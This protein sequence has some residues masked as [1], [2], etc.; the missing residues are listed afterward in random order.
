MIERQVVDYKYVVDSRL[1]S[2]ITATLNFKVEEDWQKLFLNNEQF[3]KLDNKMA[4]K[5]Y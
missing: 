3:K 2:K 5:V 1:L 4:D